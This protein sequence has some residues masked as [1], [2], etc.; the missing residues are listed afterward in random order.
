[1]SDRQV[2]VLLTGG[3]GAG[4]SSVG[5]LL[6]ARGAL[7]IDADQVGH[8]VLEPGGEA[9]KGV[10]E[11]WPSVVVDGVIDRSRLADI[12]F[13]DRAE[14][15]LLEGFTHHAI[16]QRIADLVRGS[17]EQV[18]VVQV[19][20]LT[21]FMGEGWLR[22]V[23]DAEPDVRGNRLLRRG[24]EADDVR[25]RMKSQPARRQWL[26][27]ADWVVDNSGSFDE[28]AGRVDELWR[29]LQTMASS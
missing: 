27:A 5:E 17:K 29:E 19:P 15:E 13:R 20:L 24:M 22:V 4:K 16:R 21:D 25:R 3:I 6:R 28:L 8:Q 1:M 7:V 18:V 2:R 11:N 14:L 23:V 12:V 10:A 9:F 26:E